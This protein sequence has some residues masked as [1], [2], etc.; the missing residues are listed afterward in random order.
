[1][2][3]G[4]SKKSAANMEAIQADSGLEEKLCNC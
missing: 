3:G 4:L 2:G 1:M